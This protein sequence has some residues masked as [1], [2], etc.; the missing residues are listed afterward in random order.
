M[1]AGSGSC[2]FKQ[3]ACTSSA[4]GR[5]REGGRELAIAAVEKEKAERCGCG[6]GDVCWLTDSLHCSVVGE[7]LEVGLGLGGDWGWG[8]WAAESS[9]Q[10]GEHTG[11]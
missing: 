3:D 1:M 10:A 9:R 6:C 7:G 11:K 4:K 5:E 2:V 8:F